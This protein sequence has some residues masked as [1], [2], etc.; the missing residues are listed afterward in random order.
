MMN[1]NGKRV[2]VTGGTGFL[3]RVVVRKLQQQQAIVLAVRSTDCDLCDR[4]QSK[5]FFTHASPD[6]VIHC[7]VQGG[8]IGWMKQ[9]P[10]D[11]GIDNVRMNINALEAAHECGADAFIGVSSACAYPKICPIPFTEADLWEGYP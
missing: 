2:L 1:W 9:Y 7:A 3:G 5:K 8:G 4:V 10:V 6:V 11:S